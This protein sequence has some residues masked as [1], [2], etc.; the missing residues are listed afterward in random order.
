MINEAI[1]NEWHRFYLSVFYVVL[2]NL[3]G[4]I[5]QYI[6]NFS[7]VKFGSGVIRRMRSAVM[8]HIA[9]LYVSDIESKH[10]GDLVSRLV[11]DVNATQ[12]LIN[13]A[14][15]IFFQ[16]LM[17]ICAFVYIFTVSWKIALFSV[18]SSPIVSY[19]AHRLSI[20]IGG[21]SQEI[22]VHM[23]EANSVVQDSIGGMPILKAFNLQNVMF[24][25]Y[26]VLI[27]M[28]YKRNVDISKREVMITAFISILQMTPWSLSI[29]F[30][31][32]L[33]MHG[34]MTAGALIALVNLLS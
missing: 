27:D 10:S 1:G 3:L 13:T 2:I 6:V 20:V 12:A 14:S 5:V 8:S 15:E 17:F 4:F 34:E 22:R 21:Y 26:K 23:G 7:Q 24:E 18:V 9:D 31:G 30:S 29:L 28:V 32:Y 11:N 19:V 16:P 25:R 33:A